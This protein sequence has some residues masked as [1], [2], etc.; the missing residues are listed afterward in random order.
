MWDLLIHQGDMCGEKEEMLCGP[1]IKHGGCMH[2]VGL[3][4]IIL[5]LE[6]ELFYLSIGPLST[7]LS[8][9]GSYPHFIH[10]MYCGKLN[11]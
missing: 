2:H 7:G 11:G 3:L 1:C 4:C 9:C 10:T 6:L 5:K 8:N